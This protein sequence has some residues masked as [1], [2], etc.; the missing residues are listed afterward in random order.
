MFHRPSSSVLSPLLAVLLVLSPFTANAD[1]LSSGMIR[2]GG[3]II[4]RDGEILEQYRQQELFQTA[5]TIKLLTALTVLDT[6][7]GNYR[8]STSFFMDDSGVLYIRGSGDPFLTSEYLSR[9]AAELSDRGITRVSGYVLDDSAFRL[10]HPLPDGS[11][12]SHNPYDAPNGG[13]AVNFNSISIIKKAN[14]SAGTGEVQTPTIPITTE[15]AK[16]L[17]PGRH[18]ININHIEVNGSIPAQLRYT[19]ELLHEFLIREGVTSTAA[20]RQG[21]VTDQAR[22]LYVFTSPKN[23]AELLQACLHFSNN[24]IANQL[25]LT[26][27]AARYGAPA[28]WKK[29]QNLLHGYASDRLHLESDQFRVVEGSGLSRKNRMSPEAMLTVLEHFHPHRHLLP[30]RKGTLLKSGT[31]ES[32]YCYAGYLDKKESHTS[33]VFLLNQEKNIRGTLLDQMKK[34]LPK[35]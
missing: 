22:Q 24:F 30:R 29:A 15:I 7:G 11:E 21:E 25:L 16:H 35:S 10:E 31:M 34:N 6:L 1:I 12:N 18:R 14:G 26:A 9:I 33:F 28:T 13:L 17:R 8:Y 20:V 3:Y 23:V 19:A 32:V 27:A 2:N 4:N 5:S